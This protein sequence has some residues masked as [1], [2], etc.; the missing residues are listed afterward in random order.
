LSRDELDQQLRSVLRNIH[1]YV[2]LQNHP[3]ATLLI[4]LESHEGPTRAQKLRRMLLE[5]IERLA[6]AQDAP[7]HGHQWRGYHILTSRYVEGQS[8]EEVRRE[9]ALSERQYYREHQAALQALTDQMWERLC[10]QMAP[11]APEPGA[12]RAD[13]TLT[14]LDSELRHLAESP[15]PVDLAALIG[16]V[17]QAVLPLAT[18]H[19]VSLAC[20]LP[21]ALPPIISHRTVLRQVYIQVM[22]SLLVLDGVRAVELTTHVARR[23][24][25]TRIAVTAHERAR[26][27]L[28]QLGDSLRQA[29][30]LVAQLRGEW[31]AGSERPGTYVVQLGLPTGEPRLLLAVEDN[32]GAVELMRRYLTQHPFR[33]VHARSGREAL[34]LAH[35]QLPDVITL[36]IM[37]PEQDGWE[38]LQE[39]KHDPELASIPVILASVLA[40]PAL[41]TAYS[42][43]GYLKKPFSQDELL[44]LL[45]RVLGPT[46]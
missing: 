15:E 37:L 19:G 46:D 22:S 30:H 31:D 1:D 11:T 40:E 38:I 23:R 28:D 41:T 36:D 5:A 20:H 24:V 16:G 32:P 2:F 42:L 8:G 34:A 33:V 6:P 27:P 10:E 9:L 17:R 14:S 35:E 39:L 4:P 7:L 13:E 44:T 25:W 43:A 18:H 29:R 26:L 12:S 45:D 3:L 21:S